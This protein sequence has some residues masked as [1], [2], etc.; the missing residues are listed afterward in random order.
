MIIKSRRTDGRYIGEFLQGI[1]L[2]IFGEHA[3]DSTVIKIFFNIFQSIQHFFMC[4][5]NV[6]FLSTHITDTIYYPQDPA[7]LDQYSR[8]F[9]IGRDIDTAVRHQKL[10]QL[11]LHF[12]TGSVDV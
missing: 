2:N 7:M 4:P 1:S 11:L 5:F 10:W 6:Y 12:R 8:F 9:N 3:I